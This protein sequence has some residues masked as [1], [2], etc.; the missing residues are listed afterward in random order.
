MKALHLTKSK[1]SAYELYTSDYDVIVVLF[2]FVDT[3]RLR[4]LRYVD[5]LKS[6]RKQTSGLIPMPERP[7]CAL[8]SHFW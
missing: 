8:L 1:A 3:S 2:E 4:L 6:Y 7:V 5:A